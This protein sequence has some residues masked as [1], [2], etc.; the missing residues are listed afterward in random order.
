MT[1]VMDFLS[2]ALP[3]LGM[4]LALAVF[5]AL[6]DANEKNRNNDDKE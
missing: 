5:F 6:Y 3:W 2:V 4:G 1:N